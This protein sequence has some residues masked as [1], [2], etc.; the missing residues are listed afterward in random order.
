MN[1]WKWLPW[2]REFLYRT[3]KLHFGQYETWG[4]KCPADRQ[5]YDEVI[6]ELAVYFSDEIGKPITVEAIKCQ[7]RWAITNQGEVD[8][9]HIV[10][11]LQN[12][13][14]AH[15]VGFIGTKLLPNQALL[16]YPTNHTTEN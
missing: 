12:K 13:A 14:I 11:F 2:M 3:L 7:I 15:F 16:E 10:Q 4:G 8:A 9:A 5:A 1:R 6:E